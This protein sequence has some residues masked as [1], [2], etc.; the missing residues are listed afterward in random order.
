[1][2]FATPKN[3]PPKKRLESTLVGRDDGDENASAGARLEREKARIL[4]DDAMRRERKAVRMARKA[5]KLP[6]PGPLV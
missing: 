6:E 5:K 3:L 4:G 2:S 1:M